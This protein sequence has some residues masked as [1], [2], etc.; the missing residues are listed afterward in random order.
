MTSP[1]DEEFTELVDADIPRVDLV[2]KAANGMRFLI[3]KND[4]SAGLMDPEFVRD[5]LAKSEP[6]AAAE[7][8]TM[9]GSP[10]AIAGLIH[11]AA[12]RAA[13]PVEKAEMAVLTEDASDGDD[14]AKAGPKGYEHGWIKVG[15][16]GESKVHGHL[17]SAHQAIAEG[18]HADAVNHL[19]A[20]A[21][22]AEDPK[23]KAA[24][25]EMRN[26]IAGQLMGRKPKKMKKAEAEMDDVTDDD[27]DPTAPLA[28]ADGDAS[29]DPAVPGTP[30]WEA[31]DAATARKWT[32]ILV[33]ARHA[34]G[35][36]SDRE[37]MES[38]TGN[39]GDAM[40]A[41]DLGNAKAAI[42]CAIDVLAGYAVDEQGEADLAGD[43]MS[44][45]G[46]ALADF[47]PTVLDTIEVLAPIAK[48]GRTLSAANEAAI[49]A[50]TESLQKVLASLPAA[51][52]SDDEETD[53]VAKQE[54]ETMTATD[55]APVEVPTD[56]APVVKADGEKTP[57]V[58]V[59][60]AAGKLVGVVDPSQLTPVVA[61]GAEMAAE[62]KGDD[63]PADVPNADDMS[64]DETPAEAAD[65]TPAPAAHVGTP[66][67]AVHDD[68]V[69]KQTETTDTTADNNT[70]TPSDA[71]LKSSIANVVK[72]ELDAYSA[73]LQEVIAKQ[74]T[75]LT[76]MAETIETLKGQVRALEDQPAEP[77]VFTNG[78]V[79]PTAALRGQNRGAAAQIDVASAQELR[80]GLYGSGDAGEQKRV[81]DTMQGLAIARLQEIHQRPASQ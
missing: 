40:A 50:A 17:A 48:A 16:P 55:T 81:A 74:A 62:D 54:E 24:I 21:G 31:I 73:P 45:V 28:A 43:A 6:D 46:K 51:P 72:A 4:D 80:K 38:T 30:A 64:N 32:S 76:G 36:L 34:L 59:Y 44:A 19:T 52:Q 23:A 7:Q 41:M 71:D 58:P 66:A 5:L 65:L 57:Q 29:G 68:D 42:G 67:D 70:D 26:D 39:A 79:P 2:D 75:A 49:R 10:G 56:I 14:V 77:K 33:R 22:H 63:K 60:D 13:D 47:D 9:T 27:M 69:T 15:A 78:A 3:A 20:A 11:R 18:R 25:T 1:L 35:M 53:M 8:V 37:M 12:Q 61:V